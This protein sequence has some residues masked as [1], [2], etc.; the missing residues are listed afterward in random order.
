MR[1]CCCCRC[2]LHLQQ[3]SRR[4]NFFFLR[5]L[6]FSN[7]LCILRLLAKSLAMFCCATVGRHWYRRT[8]TQC[9]SQH[10]TWGVHVY[11]S[12][13]R[14]SRLL[15]VDSLW[16]LKHFLISDL[17]NRGVRN[18]LNVGTKE[19]L[20][21]QIPKSFVSFLILSLC[22]AYLNWKGYVVKTQL[23]Q[24]NVYW[25]VHHCN[26]WGMKNQLDVTCHFISLLMR[27][28]CFGH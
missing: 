18:W 19:D 1:Y 8:K 28:T 2:I 24:S 7:C 27:S 10:M 11:V 15:P 20:G 16:S 5:N 3:Y 13:A 22:R 25:T 6:K 9:I 12:A 21:V 26:S 14:W 4:L 17:I 23:C